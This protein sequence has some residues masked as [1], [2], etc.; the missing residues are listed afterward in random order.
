MYS[1]M[2]LMLETSLSPELTTYST[3]LQGTHRFAQVWH[4]FRKSRVGLP[5]LIILLL[6]GISVTLIPF[7]LP[8]DLYTT[9]P[10]QVFAPVGTVDTFAFVGQTHWLGTDSL[11]RDVMLRL[12]VAGRVTLGMALVST[13]FV[14][15]IGSVLGAMAGHYG[16]LIDSILMRFTDFLLALPLLPLFLF[17]LRLIRQSPAIVPLLS[18]QQT[19]T[20]VTLLIITGVFVLLGW[21]GLARLVRGSVLSLRTQ[22]YI[23][24]AYALGATNRRIIFKHLLPNTLGPIMVAATFAVGDFIILEATIHLSPPG[25]TCSPTPRVS[26]S[27]SPTLT[28]SKTSAPTYSSS[29][30]SSS[31]SQSS[32]S[33]T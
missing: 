32:P 23:E 27:T 19:N 3:D 15:L 18:D 30:P 28:H 31:S 7:L 2:P 9:N 25:A 12:F 13:L 8:F 22:S 6:L 5:S 20:L 26:P 33:T 24:S 4:R 16:G 29:P 1:V 10:L 11:G 14:V 17:V 21:M